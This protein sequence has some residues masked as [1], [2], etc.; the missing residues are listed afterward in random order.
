MNQ[1]AIELA[2]L[3]VLV[4]K[5]T[6]SHVAEVCKRQDMTFSDALE[7]LLN[8]GERDIGRMKW[9]GLPDAQATEANERVKVAYEA[10]IDAVALAAS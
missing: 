2:A 7:E 1:A 5:V 10:L 9:H 6:A 8:A 3:R 4:V